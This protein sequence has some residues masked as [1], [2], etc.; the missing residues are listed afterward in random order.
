MVEV[1]DADSINRFRTNFDGNKCRI[2]DNYG[3]VINVSC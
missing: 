3:P 1:R 2:E